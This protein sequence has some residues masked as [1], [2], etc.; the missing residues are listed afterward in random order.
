MADLKSID[1]TQGRRFEDSLRKPIIYNS[2]GTSRLKK[3]EVPHS[4]Y[5]DPHYDVYI[6]DSDITI[7]NIDNIITY[8]NLSNSWNI[9]TANTSTNDGFTVSTT[10]ST[11]N[12]WLSGDIISLN[13]ILYYNTY[14]NDWSSYKPRLYNN[15]YNSD[16][17]NSR[18]Q[19]DPFE[20]TYS[21]DLKYRMKK[22]NDGIWNNSHDIINRLSHDSMNKPIVYDDRDLLREYETKDNDDLWIT[23][24]TDNFR[25]ME[26]N[27]KKKAPFIK[28]VFT[29]NR[30]RS[31]DFEDFKLEMIKAKENFDIALSRL[32]I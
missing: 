8:T 9:T 21:S 27:L 3:G 10:W 30:G 16:D 17:I 1:L 13:D 31:F 2:R 24:S 5:D 19:K 15:H 22:S 11:E 32:H 25:K 26:R 20:D 23:P 12:T 29:M 6:S 28:R 4:L 7:T 18:M 14:Y